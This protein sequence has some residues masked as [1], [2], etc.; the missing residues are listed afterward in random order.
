MAD[1]FS[2]ISD[3]LLKSSTTNDQALKGVISVL[4]KC[5]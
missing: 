1:G 4:E 5:Y 2:R 3:A